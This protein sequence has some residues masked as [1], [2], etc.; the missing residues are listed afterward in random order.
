MIA[1]NFIMGMGARVKVSNN[2]LTAIT[3]DQMTLLKYSELV[4]D[5]TNTYSLTIYYNQFLNLFNDYTIF[6]LTSIRGKITIKQSKPDNE[7]TS[8]ILNDLKFTKNLNID[9]RNLII[10]GNIYNPTENKNDI[11]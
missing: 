2:A 5:F 3:I 1:D 8:I 6:D 7:R 11:T 9:V 4:F 10:H